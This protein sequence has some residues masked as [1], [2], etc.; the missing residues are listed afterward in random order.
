[1]GRGAFGPGA[2]RARSAGLAETI[3]PPGFTDG[4]GEAP[5]VAAVLSAG[6]AWACPPAG[7]ALWLPDGL[8]LP[9]PTIVMA[10]MATAA[11]A[12]V[13]LTIMLRASNSRASGPHRRP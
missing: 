7:L 13:D 8:A 9:Q 6:A 12:R 2:R 4:T 5:E 1:M 3:V 10:D 11:T